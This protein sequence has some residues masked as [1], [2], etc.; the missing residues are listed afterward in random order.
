MIQLY[1]NKSYLLDVYPKI[2][3]TPMQKENTLSVANTLKNECHLLSNLYVDDA[4]LDDD[5]DGA[6]G[7][8]DPDDDDEFDGSVQ[9][10]AGREARLHRVADGDVSLHRERRDRQYRRI[11]RRLG[12]QSSA[13]NQ[14][15]C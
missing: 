3:D 15:A 9:A 11:R 14:L 1:V 13:Q 6:D 5:G 7:G 10:A 12:R 4:I 2:V 8:D